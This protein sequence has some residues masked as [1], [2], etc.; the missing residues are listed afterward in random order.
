MKIN[1]NKRPERQSPYLAMAQQQAGVPTQQPAVQPGP[2]AQAEAFGSIANAAPVVDENRLKEFTR[3]LQEYKSGKIHT[4]RR[5]IASENWWK[6]RNTMEE[7]K[8]TRVGTDGGFTSRSGWL[9]PEGRH[10][11]SPAMWRCLTVRN[12]WSI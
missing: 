5:I 7:Q 11:P 2:N 1:D 9:Q 10:W 6:L 4:E 12:L 8:E 3:I